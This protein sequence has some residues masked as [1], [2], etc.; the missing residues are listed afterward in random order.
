[1]DLA[2][3]PLT[4]L[5]ATI[6]ACVGA[7]VLLGGFVAGLLDHLRHGGSYEPSR[8]RGGGYAG[9]LISILALLVDG[10]LLR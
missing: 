1:M 8:A 2:A 6:A 4:S 9:G 5:I 7:G 10:L 3:G